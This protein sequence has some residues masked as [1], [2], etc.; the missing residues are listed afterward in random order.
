METG[1]LSANAAATA[2]SENVVRFISW[3]GPHQLALKSIKIARCV[4]AASARAAARSVRHGIASLLTPLPPPPLP[5]SP[6]PGRN[7]KAP[8]MATN[9]ATNAAWV[10]LFI[11]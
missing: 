11:I 9:N 3:Q 10:D 5:P 8:T 6:Q 4:R 2:G 1:I 7:A